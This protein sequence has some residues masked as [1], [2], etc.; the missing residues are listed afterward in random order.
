MKKTLPY[1]LFFGGL[2]IDL[3]AMFGEYAEQIPF[4]TRIVTPSYYH[5]KQ[6]IKTLEREGSLSK[7]AKGY[8]EISKILL[9]QATSVMFVSKPMIP[10]TDLMATNR[11][12]LSFSTNFSIES[13]SEGGGLFFSHG[14]NPITDEIRYVI[15][16]KT[17]PFIQ[18][19]GAQES[20]KYD[21]T[22]TWRERELDA[23]IEELKN[24][25]ILYF[26]FGL[27]FFGASIATIGYFMERNESAEKPPNQMA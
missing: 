3:V 4:V 6:G 17:I 10:G 18:P 14:G 26:V 27:F 19:Q 20:P 22:G 16:S 23:K 21:S 25:N 9:E 12:D 8:D 11:P 15:H 13:I 1:I 2:L 24:P 7:G 5:A